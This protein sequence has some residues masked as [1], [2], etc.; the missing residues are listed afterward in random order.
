MNET[1]LQF[2][3]YPVE[4][5]YGATSSGS[6]F[7]MALVVSRFAIGAVATVAETNAPITLQGTAPERGEVLEIKKSGMLYL[8][9]LG[10]V[11]TQLIMEVAVGLWA[12]QVAVPPKDT[13]SQAQVLRSMMD[14]PAQHGSSNHPGTNSSSRKSTSELWVYRAAATETAD[15]FDCYMERFEMEPAGK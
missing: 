1:T 5:I 13:V 3:T 2:Q 8:I 7:S 10:I 14:G 15:V 11:L 4:S 6:A 9:L 12:H